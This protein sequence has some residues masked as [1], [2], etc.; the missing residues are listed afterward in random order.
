M[1]NVILTGGTG[2]IGGLVLQECIKSP[3]IKKVI[4]IVRRPTGIKHKK[5]TEIVH[6]DFLDY[7]KIETQCKNIDVAYYCLGVYTGAVP[8]E[9]FREIT[10]GYT[11]AFASALRKI[12]PK[13]TFC[14]LSGVGA[15]RKEKSRMMFAQDKG[16]AEN[17]LLRLPCGRSISIL[18]LII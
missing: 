3:D 8:R 14:F 15:D 18:F 6:D 13:A 4:S 11:K 10:V 12:S 16:I 7:S 1:K 9:K 17:F 5:L 2:M